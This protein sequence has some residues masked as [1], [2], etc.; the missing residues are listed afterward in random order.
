MAD[1]FALYDYWRRCLADVDLRSPNPNDTAFPLSPEDVTAG[2]LPEAVAQKILDEAEKS[3]RKSQGKRQADEN[4]KPSSVALLVAPFG[5]RRYFH[6]GTPRE[7]DAQPYY[8]LWIPA[9]L[10]RE[11]ATLSGAQYS[12]WISRDFL[13]PVNR[14][15]PVI[16]NLEDLEH[17]LTQK[18]L[19]TGAAWPEVLA[20]AGDM[21]QAVTGHTLSD[22][23]L[24]EFET[25]EPVATL[26]KEDKGMATAI[27]RLYDQILKLKSLPPL[28]RTLAAGA[29]PR[30]APEPYDLADP[31]PALR[32]C[33]Q[34]SSAFPLSPSQRQAVQGALS[35]QDGELL[36][37]NGPPGTGKTTLL[38][39]VVASLWVQA[40]L[41]GA[42]PPVIV[43][44]ST[45]N[46]A[47]T[48]VLD[49]FAAAAS[50]AG[51]NPLAGRWLPEL[52][53]YG[54]YLPS[55][56][57]LGRSS[58]QEAAPGYP[59]WQGLPEIMETPRY[60]GAAEP[61]FLGKARAALAG[62][63]SGSVADAVA[64]LH[65]R[66][67]AVQS[68]IQEV[69]AHARAVDSCRREH[70]MAT[71]ESALR[72][73]GNEEAALRSALTD[74]EALYA[75][76]LAALAGIPF[77]EDM[78]SFL[79]PI[80]K[81]RA[82][83]LSFPF[84]QRHLEPPAQGGADFAQAVSRQVKTAVDQTR[85]RLD[86]LTHWR[87]SEDLLAARL[88][89][90][91]AGPMDDLRQV[92]DLLDGLRYQAFLLAGRYWEGRWLL[93][94][95]KLIDSG[96][97]LTAQSRAACEARLRRF[98]MLTPC[99][100]ATF[101]QAPKVFIFYDGATRQELPL[102]S[103]MD[104]LIV[105]EAGQVTPEVGAATFALAKQALVVGDVHQIEPVWSVLPVVDDGN[106]KASGIAL[107]QDEESED[108]KAFRACCGSVMLLGRRATATTREGE[109][110]LF[111]SEHR[112]SVPEVIRFCNELVYGGRL[113]PLRSS[114]KDRVLPPLGWAH[115]TATATADG[116]S[117]VN[118]GEAQVIADWIDRHRRQLEE[119]HQRPISEIVAVITP[120]V[121]QKGALD[122]AFRSLKLTGVQAGTV[123][124]F[125]GAE[126]PVVL[127]S[128]VYGLAD[129]PKTLFFDVGSNLLN[130]AV[131]RARDSFLVF[132][133]LRVF[134]ATRT[135]LP[136]G[137][138]A[139]LLFE[140]QDNEI[141]DVESAQHLKGKSG[142]Q[143]L[144]GL[145]EHRA[146]L[147]RA[148]DRGKERIL[149][150]SP[151][152]SIHA[153]EADDVP[154]AVIAAK[155]RGARVCVVFSRDLS[156]PSTPKTRRAIESLEQAGAEVKASRRIHSKTL[157]V[158]DGWIAE[159]SFNWL[160]ASRDEDSSFQRH[161]AS[162][163]YEGPDV[164]EL[165]QAA[166]REALVAQ[167]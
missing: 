123:H 102:I 60:L 1:S 88:A 138:L 150:V 65:R 23:K 33:G 164:K 107:P 11:G 133:D 34:M 80:R 139:A 109:R 117:R 62:T 26:W 41:A 163:L 66:M 152:L 155:A 122:R 17:F 79:P 49:S 44:C 46:Q 6:H 83:R 50:T 68:R 59:A 67:S 3:L 90:I 10:S 96:Q 162:I 36:A 73:I 92:L 81:R 124:A 74:Q 56:A 21:L 19:A 25:L 114:K 116:G 134:D 70:G 132:G 4:E 156:S 14:D 12:P 86:K 76:V 106:L 113:Q 111:L 151:Y 148:L 42:E 147:R 98:S 143:R 82:L 153:V 100:V 28:L 39:S 91:G 78:L 125:Q 110:G 101:Y 58:Y 52:A 87:Q 120:F 129:A 119:H 5:L 18:R 22:L 43:A 77:W 29:E 64:E 126:R 104:L 47:V 158:D 108:A 127:F 99:M 2:R 53:S 135:V 55:Q 7:A 51:E 61:F 137:K 20:F 142:I 166:W 140:S 165:V 31:E 38:Q 72:F 9:R 63:Q 167:R 144:A 37:V 136:S 54:L 93:E 27:L 57:R 95:T 128:P 121:A 149:I 32:H 40:A 146:A 160:S 105:D 154:S 161:E 118:L 103:F 35:L 94:M 13:R 115:V 24:E 141:T 89:E 85:T 159:G 75:E 15:S 84:L 145:S 45:N 130:V 30:R 112:R 97:K 48:N 69:I 16:G 157:A 71:Y 131:S 8:P